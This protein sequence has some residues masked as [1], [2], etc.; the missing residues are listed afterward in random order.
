[1]LADIAIAAF[2][3]SLVRPPLQVLDSAIDL[4]APGRYEVL[5]IRGEQG[6]KAADTLAD[7]VGERFLRLRQDEPVPPAGKRRPAGHS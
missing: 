6:D 4:P 1:M 2:P 7:H 5:V 3:R